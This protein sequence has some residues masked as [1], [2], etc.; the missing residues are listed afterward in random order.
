[1]GILNFLFRHEAPKISREQALLIAKSACERN[2][3]PWEAPFSVKLTWDEYEILTNTDMLGGNVRI[4][5]DKDD[6]VVT[7]LALDRR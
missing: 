4:H 2:D 1:M 6:G 7:L 3:L 5:I